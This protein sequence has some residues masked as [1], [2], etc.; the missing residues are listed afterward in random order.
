MFDSYFQFMEVHEQEQR[1]LRIKELHKELKEL[2]GLSGIAWSKRPFKYWFGRSR[3]ER[4]LKEGKARRLQL[5]ET[6]LESSDKT[7]RD[8]VNANLQLL[9][10]DKAFFKVTTN[11]MGIISSYATEFAGSI[12]DNGYA[13]C[14][15]VSGNN[16]LDLLADLAFPSRLSGRVD[17][18]GNINLAASSTDMAFF[19]TLPTSFEGT[20]DSDGQIILKLKSS[21]MDILSGGRLM[22]D[23]LMA[24]IIGMD[25]R[26]TAQFVSNKAELRSMIKRFEESVLDQ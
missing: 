6:Y 3:I 15:S 25:K 26:K 16:P 12:H 20:I 11:V 4:H 18:W 2:E 10:S 1:L 21:E 24:N 14:Q 19:K 23:K 5:I 9:S 13:Y 22:I 17:Y 8:L 7:Y